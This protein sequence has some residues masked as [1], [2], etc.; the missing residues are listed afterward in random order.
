MSSQINKDSIITLTLFLMLI[1]SFYFIGYWLIYR[2]GRATPLMLSAGAAAL[3]TCVIRK[4]SIG[5]M[6]WH[7]GEWKYQRLSYLLPLLII[8]FAHLLIWSLGL[9]EWYNVG[10]LQDLKSDYNLNEWSDVQVLVFH[11]L[12]SSTI[13]FLLLLPSVLGEEIAWR[14]F[15]VPEL[16][17]FMSFTGVALTSGL[18]WAMWHWPLIILGLSGNDQTPLYYQ[19]TC[20]TVFLV[21]I[22]FIL[23]YLR[24]KTGSLWTAVIF[25]MSI[26][27]FL[28]KVFVL[29]I[30]SFVFAVIY[31]RK[32]SEC[33]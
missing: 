22:S 17:N 8:F 12:I 21:S 3:L 13:S 33:V 32:R 29:A 30:V 7:W 31:W 24:L 14:G 25:H 19:L 16:A 20:F 10:F 28:Q 2:L 23:T 6:G 5:L 1:V 4:R 11:F 18:A 15:L 26:N 27:L 9:A